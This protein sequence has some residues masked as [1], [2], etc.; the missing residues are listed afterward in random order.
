MIWLSHLISHFP[1]YFSLQSHLPLCFSWQ[2]KDASISTW[3]SFLSSLFF[4]TSNVTIREGFTGY[5]TYNSTLPHHFLH[6][7]PSLYFFLF[8][9]SLILLIIYVFDVLISPLKY[10]FHEIRDIDLFM[11][12]YQVPGQALGIK[13]GFN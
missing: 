12:V 8:S 9:M 10:K 7:D 3:L 6:Y 5:P 4:F 1:I 13:H 2:A 11:I